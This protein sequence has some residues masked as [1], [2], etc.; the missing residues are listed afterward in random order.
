VAA[1]NPPPPAGGS[2]TPAEGGGTGTTQA[3]ADACPSKGTLQC[4]GLQFQICNA[5]GSPYP[6]LGEWLS[7]RIGEADVQTGRHLVHRALVFAMLPK[8]PC[9]AEALLGQRRML[10]ARNES[11]TDH[12]LI[13]S[14]L[15]VA[16]QLVQSRRAEALA[17]AVPLDFPGVLP[18]QCVTHSEPGG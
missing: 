14:E 18:P 8:T 11:R 16:I 4:T 13:C 6:Y 15:H 12:C 2:G 7:I 3:P 1:A 17:L 10:R 5:V 9:V